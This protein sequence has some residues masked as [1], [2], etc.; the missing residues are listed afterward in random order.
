MKELGEHLCETLDG[1]LSGSEAK[2]LWLSALP[3]IQANL[4]VG[5]NTIA[6]GAPG[7]EEVVQA[8]REETAALILKRTIEIESQILSLETPRLAAPVRLLRRLVNGASQN[9]ESI[10]V[11]TTNYDTLVE[12]FCDLAEVPVDT[13][14]SGQRRRYARVA[15]LFQTSYKRSLTPGKR[16]AAY[17]YRPSLTVRVMKPHGSINW[18]T[19]ADGPVEV[20]NDISDAP[21]AIVVP[22]PTKYEDALVS[23][24]FDGMRSEMNSSVA[25]ATALMCIGFGFNDP[26]LQ[27]VI[28]ARLEAGM[29]TLIIV[30][31]LTPNI[32]LLIEQ[33]PQIIAFSK[34]GSGSVVHHDRMKLHFPDPL[35]ELDRFLVT[36]LE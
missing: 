5:L 35:W 32:S 16:G 6:N 31:D 2:Q 9:A 26:H 1:K 10:S 12:L 27:N 34:S 11:I 25:K 13:G 24:L 7:R 8:L 17:E 30:K 29:P 22:G 23:T 33:H 4:E 20:L 36:Y 3:S 19:T 18:Q 15:P 14:F 28:R 21:R